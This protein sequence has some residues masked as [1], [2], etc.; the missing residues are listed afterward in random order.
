[1]IIKF[2]VV[3]EIVVLG[4]AMSKLKIHH[5]KK[6]KQDVIYPDTEGKDD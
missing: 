4:L 6:G 3:I 2:L 1:M 5:Y